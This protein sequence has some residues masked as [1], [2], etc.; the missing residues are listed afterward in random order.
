M[1]ILGL[2]VAVL[3]LNGCAALKDKKQSTRYYH[4]REVEIE[5]RQDCNGDIFKES[6][7]GMPTNLQYS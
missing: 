7:E 1:K 6:G 2:I 3:I 4:F 5:L